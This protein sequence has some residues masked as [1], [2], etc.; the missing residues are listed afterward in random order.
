MAGLQITA[1]D[2][3]KIGQLMLDE[4]VWRGRRILSQKWVRESIRPGQPY[5]R[6]CG[7]LWWLIPESNKLTLDDDSIKDMK[8][9]LGLSEASAKKLQTMKVEPSQNSEFWRRVFRIFA[10]DPATKARLNE[11]NEQ[12]KKKSPTT[13]IVGDG[14]TVAFS[15]RGYLGQ[16]LVVVPNHRIVA[17]RQRR[18]SEKHDPYDP[19]GDFGDFETMVRALVK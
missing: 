8:A 12:F 18:S 7:L 15:A 5:D 2:F 11:I 10:A 9:Q 13:K 14:P 19:T 4:G 3:A 16:F 17:V 1:I 6:S